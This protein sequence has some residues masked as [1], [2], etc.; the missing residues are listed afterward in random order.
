MARKKDDEF[1]YFILEIETGFID[2]W[3][4]NA[5]IKEIEEIA[6]YCNEKRPQYQHIACKAI[7][8]KG[9]NK[10]KVMFIN[11]CE[12]EE[13]KTQQEKIDDYLHIKNSSRRMN[14]T[15]VDLKITKDVDIKLQWLCNK[16]NVSYNDAVD[17]LCNLLIKNEIESLDGKIDD[18]DSKIANLEAENKMLIDFVKKVKLNLRESHK[19]HVQ[20]EFKIV[21]VSSFID[22]EDKNRILTNDLKQAKERELVLI[23]ALEEKLLLKDDDKIFA[24]ETN[25]KKLVEELKHKKEYDQQDIQEKVYD[26]F[27]AIEPELKQA[28]IKVLCE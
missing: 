24:L 18:K 5:D 19:E 22:N 10:R 26:V 25:N 15:F 4:F 6:K 13:L 7:I 11:D 28:I 12:D 9:F 3:Y 2:G 14:S 27:N 21:N 23:N 20:K 16:I 8:P 17:R 1:E